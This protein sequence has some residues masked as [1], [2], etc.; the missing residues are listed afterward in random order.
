MGA[1]LLD[2]F[3]VDD[4]IDTA[5]LLRH[6]MVR[7]VASVDD[8][9]MNSGEG[10]FR[11]VRRTGRLRGV[12]EELGFPAAVEALIGPEE[13]RHRSRASTAGDRSGGFGLATE[14]LPGERKT[15]TKG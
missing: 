4:H 6:S 5:E 9:V 7:G 12:G 3:G 13:R 14:L 15:M 2:S 8:P 10:V 1:P 11:I